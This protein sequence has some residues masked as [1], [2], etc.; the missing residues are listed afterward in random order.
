M[1][2][3]TG[4][5]DADG[6]REEQAA[7]LARMT[8]TLRHRGPDD[9]DHWLD[10]SLGVGLGHRR[11]AIVDLSPAGHQP[12]VSA[13]GRCVLAYNGELYNTPELARDLAATGIRLGRAPATARAGRVATA[14]RR[15]CR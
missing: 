11:L 1:C 2:G 12:M 10:P 9:G 5:L 13:S 15:T 14:R 4:F 3:L 6:D 7:T 8:A